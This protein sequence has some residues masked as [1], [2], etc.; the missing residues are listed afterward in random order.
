MRTR[1]G[2]LSPL[3]LLLLGMLAAPAWGCSCAATSL[4]GIYERADNVF[5][6][7]ITGGEMLPPGE[8]FRD[9]VLMRFELI[10]RFKGTLPFQ[11]LQSGGFGGACGVSLQ[12]GMEFLVFVDDD[13]WVNTCAGTQALGGEYGRYGRMSLALLERYRRGELAELQ[14]PWLFATYGDRCLLRTHVDFPAFST[15]AELAISF[16]PGPRQESPGRAQLALS[17]PTQREDPAAGPLLLQVGSAQWSAPWTAAASR[18]GSGGYAL[19][20][21]AVLA[22]V[23]SLAQSAALHLRFEDPQHGPIARELWTGHARESSAQFSACV[24]HLRERTAA[25]RR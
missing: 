21:D 9:A 18:R 10:D 6:A 13:G 17:L 11:A 20:G 8:R 16:R 22:L 23:E 24:G 4:A 15:P 2:A 12:V 5:R 25:E 7:R 3:A 14:D 19:E 1:V